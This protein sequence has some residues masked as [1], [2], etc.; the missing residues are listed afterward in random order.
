ML[1]ELGNPMEVC[2]CGHRFFNHATFFKLKII[3]TFKRGFHQKAM[4]LIE[5]IRISEV[6]R[7]KTSDVSSVVEIVKLDVETCSIDLSKEERLVY[8]NLWRLGQLRVQNIISGPCAGR[9]SVMT[10]IAEINNLRLVADHPYLIQYDSSWDL[11]LSPEVQRSQATLGISAS[12]SLTALIASGLFK[13]SSKLDAIM[14][15]LREVKKDAKV[16]I[17]SSFERFLQLIAFSLSREGSWM[18]S[19]MRHIRC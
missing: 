4:A 15:S 19:H 9:T 3:D 14:K 11:V 10:A 13:N 1:R 5:E 16:L 17:F 18:A 7:V 12:S 2:E 8:E 6:Y